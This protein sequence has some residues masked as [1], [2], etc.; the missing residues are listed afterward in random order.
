MGRGDPRDTLAGSTT[1]KI[2][3][4]PGKLQKGNGIKG[5][6]LL[7]P[8]HLL[9]VPSIRKMLLDTEEEGIYCCIP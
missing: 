3:R 9:S 7:P 8:S 4:V 5:L 1:R 6:T 2:H